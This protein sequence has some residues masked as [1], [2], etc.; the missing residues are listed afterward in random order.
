MRL[1]L[2]MLLAASAGCATSSSNAVPGSGGIVHMFKQGAAGGHA[3]CYWFDTPAG[4]VVVDTPLTTSEAKKL[5]AELA[6]PYRIYI[7]AA[8]PERFAGIGVLRQPDVPVYTSPA[9]ATEIKN[10]GDTRLMRAASGGDVPS[11]VDPPSPAI[12]ERTR[13]MIADQIEIELIPLGPAESEASLAVY[14]PKTGELIAGDVIA[15]GEHVDLTWGRSVVWQDRIAELKALEP[16]LVY[17][18]HGTPGGAELLDQTLAYLK[19]FHDT[20]ASRVKPGAPARISSADSMAIKQMVTARFPM[21]GRPELLDKSIPA[22]YAVQLAA[23]PAAPVAEPTPGTPA[24]TTTPS[25][26]TPGTTPGSP[27]PPAKTSAATTSTTTTTTPAAKTATTPAAK[28]APAASSTVDDLLGEG[29]GGKSK[30]KKK[31]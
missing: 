6:R 4:P 2:M 9:I 23:L 13:D 12:E 5:A 27:T 18:G 15:G 10:H 21:L 3:N 17:P 20:V 1:T 26:T 31:K 8:H 22:E 16:K 14:L 25:G 29:S 19:F 7:T 28:T 11:H 30:K 24:T